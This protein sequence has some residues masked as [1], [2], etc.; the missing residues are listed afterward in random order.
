MR[1]QDVV[2]ALK[3]RGLYPKIMARLSITRQALDSWRVVPAER[4]VIVA[5]ISGYPCHVIRPD[6]FPKAGKTRRLVGRRTML[7]QRK[8]RR[9]GELEKAVT[10]MDT[11]E[12]KRT[13][14]ILGF[15][16]P[17]AVGAF[18]DVDGRTSRRWASSTTEIPQPIA[19]WLRFMVQEKLTP[20]SVHERTK[21]RLE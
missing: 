12:F 16:H 14:K 9:E 17:S 3:E 20:E 18:F 5:E 7:G 21:R 11:D 1:P 10:P 2:P 4:V 8:L 19:M 6:I 13:I 15:P